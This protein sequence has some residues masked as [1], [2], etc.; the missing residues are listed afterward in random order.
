MLLIKVVSSGLFIFVIFSCQQKVNLLRQFI[1]NKILFL[2]NVK[3]KVKHSYP[4]YEIQYQYF[5]FN[6]KIAISLQ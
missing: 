6:F 2:A 3:G 1:C 4:N 5:I